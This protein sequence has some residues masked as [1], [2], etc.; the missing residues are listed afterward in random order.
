VPSDLSGNR[1]AFFLDTFLS[2]AGMQEVG[3]KLLL[4]FLHSPHPCG[5]ATQGAV[6]EAKHKFAWSEFEQP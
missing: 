1:V 6:A 2:T 3:R 4:R 5:L